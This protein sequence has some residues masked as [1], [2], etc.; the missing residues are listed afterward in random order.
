[1]CVC[2]N[3]SVVNSN[4]RGRAAGVTMSFVKVAGSVS[5]F[6]VASFRFTQSYHLL[7]LPCHLFVRV[8]LD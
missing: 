7:L 6:D 8:M 4:K 2:S 1:M 3:V 5:I